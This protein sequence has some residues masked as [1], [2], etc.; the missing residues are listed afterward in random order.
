MQV[1]NGKITVEEQNEVLLGQRSNN[2]L[3][4]DKVLSEMGVRDIKTSVLNAL[5]RMKERSNCTDVGIKFV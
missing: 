3:N 5:H 4:S 2:T 1:L